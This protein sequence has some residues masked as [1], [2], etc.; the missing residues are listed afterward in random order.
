MFFYG[1]IA[2]IVGWLVALTTIV[3][4]SKKHYENL[5]AGTKHQKIDEVLERLIHHDEQLM[6]DSKLLKEALVKMEKD[7][8]HHVQKVGVARFNP[9]GK[10]GNSDQSFVL[11]LLNSHNSGI[12]VNFV[13][14]HEG[15]HVYCKHVE[16]GKGKEYP[17]TTEEQRAIEQSL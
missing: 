5:V 3:F 17:L 15:V 1:V 16:L 11:A 10:A 8:S 13:H 14:T 9:F 6:A 2:V 7:M 4:R 12:V